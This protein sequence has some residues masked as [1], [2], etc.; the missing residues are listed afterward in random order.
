MPVIPCA[1]S[2]VW[3]SLFS[4]RE[5]D[6]VKRQPRRLFAGIAFSAGAPLEPAALDLAALREKV[7]ALRG[8][9]R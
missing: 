3:G 2:N 7:V 9:Q 4:R 5:P 1:L 8:N 6:W